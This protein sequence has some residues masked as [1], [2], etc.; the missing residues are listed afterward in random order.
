[1]TTE[2]ITTGYAYLHNGSVSGNT[3]TYTAFTPVASD[4]ETFDPAITSLS[5]GLVRIKLEK[6]E[7]NI[8]KEQR[9]IQLPKVGSGTAPD[10]L[11]IDLNRAKNAVTIYGFLDD[12]AT[13]TALQKYEYMVALAEKEGEVSITW[14]E[15]Y[16]TGAAGYILTQTVKG[17]VEKLTLTQDA[18][19]GT[20]V[21]DVNR[22]IGVMVVVVNG[23]A[24]TTSA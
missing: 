23:S 2:T 12:D 24:I 20:I 5:V 7:R 1:M 9:Y 16:G 11:I 22:R 21:G 3:I 14:R 17:V 8:Q 10:T 13:D 19:Y 18:K 15:S 6:A 4:N